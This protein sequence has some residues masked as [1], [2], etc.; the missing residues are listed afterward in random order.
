MTSYSTYVIQ[1]MRLAACDVFIA[2]RH[3][4]AVHMLSSVCL[5]QVGVS[6]K[7]SK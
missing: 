1:T 5:I 6:L 4:S 3:A 2:R 7:T